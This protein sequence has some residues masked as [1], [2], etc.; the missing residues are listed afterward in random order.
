MIENDS[1]IV[2]GND[3]LSCFDRLEITDFIADSIISAKGLGPL[4]LMDDARIQRLKDAFL[5]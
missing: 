1:V 3:I 4:S 5:S 2:S